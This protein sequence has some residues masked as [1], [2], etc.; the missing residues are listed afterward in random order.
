MYYIFKKQFTSFPK[1]TGTDKFLSNENTVS[2]E[3]GKRCFSNLSWEG[4]VRDSVA[5][6]CE[7]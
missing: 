7:V 2:D 5:W 6:F 1:T 3:Q 4:T